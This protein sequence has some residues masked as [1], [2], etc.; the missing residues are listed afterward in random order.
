MLLAYSIYT[1]TLQKSN[2]RF[3][4]SQKLLLPTGL[5]HDVV[6]VPTFL[7]ED[8]SITTSGMAVILNINEIKAE[9]LVSHQG[10]EI[11]LPFSY[12]MVIQ[13]D[14]AVSTVWCPCCNDYNNDKQ[15]FFSETMQQLSQTLLACL[16]F[17][18]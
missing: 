1:R 15:N 3:I 16:V 11:N 12:S 13:R 9:I 10:F 17:V 8:F 4:T 6:K 7:N 2:L 18:N 5:C 14:S